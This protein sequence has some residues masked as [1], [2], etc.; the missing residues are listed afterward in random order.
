M[1][2][3]LAARGQTGDGRDQ[4]DWIFLPHTTAQKR[5]RSHFTAWLDHILRS[6]VSSSASGSAGFE[7]TLGWP[8]AITPFAL[9]LAIASAVTVG[10]R[11][12]FYPAWRASRLDPT[13]ALHH[14]QR[15]QRAG[16]VR[17]HVSVPSPTGR[18]L[19]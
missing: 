14:E 6:A 12:G 10:V 18:G 17:R 15:L 3:V 13:Q 19:G 5:F 4:D 16:P 2:G 9:L 8:I 1:V 7:R 11:F